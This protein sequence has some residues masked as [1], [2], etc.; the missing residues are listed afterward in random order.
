MKCA[1]CSVDIIADAEGDWMHLPTMADPPCCS[2]PA[3]AFDFGDGPI[4]VHRTTYAIPFSDEQLMDEGL[5]PDTRP[6]APPVPRR[7][8]MRRRLCAA[9]ATARMRAGSWVAGVDLDRECEC[10]C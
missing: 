10:G 4:V 7:V 3:P 2:D 5:I 1:N 6:P 9:F 8:R